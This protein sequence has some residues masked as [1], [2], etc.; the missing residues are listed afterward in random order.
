MPPRKAR[1]RRQAA[2]RSAAPEPRARPTAVD[3]AKASATSPS[4]SS[5]PRT[6]T[7][8]ASTTPRKAL[9]TTVKE[10]VDNALDACEEAGI[11]PDVRVE[12]RR[13][14]RRA[15]GSRSRTT[16]RASCARRC[17]RSSAACSTAR[18]ST[19][20]ARAAAS[21]ASASAP[22]GM[23]GLL[24]TGKPIAITTRTGPSEAGP[25]LR[26][27][28]R[29]QAATSRRSSATT[30]C[31]WDKPHGTRVE[32]ELEGGLPRRP[33]LRRRLPPADL[34]R[35]PARA[36][37]LRAAEGR[38]A[39]RRARLP[40]RHRRAAAG[41]ARDQAAPLRRR[42]RRA[43]ADVP[44]HQGAQPVARCLQSEFSRVSSRTAGE[45]CKR[46]KVAPTRRPS[47]I[48]ARGGGEAPPGDPGHE[49]HGAADRL[50]RAD[51]RGA[52]RARAARRG[53]G[54]LLR[55]GHAPGDAST[56]AIR[57]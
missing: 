28:D 10:G 20:C 16:A 36:D 45:I 31:E 44:R 4:R 9:L 6:A 43:D 12:I 24:T 13:S 14:P 46:A 49:D 27:R 33:A 1:G 55:G 25:P 42:A 53:E 21:R 8:S 52:D 40:A 37:H 29:H 56:A 30:T 2:R 51:R 17:R 26:A 19:A 23:Y 50:H 48:D 32:I 15:S 41:D 18:S 11:L 34:A 5:S 7:C 47:E 57:S 38:G 3:L 22:P 39:R 35:E 54:R